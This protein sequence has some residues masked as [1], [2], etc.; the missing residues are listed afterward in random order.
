MCALE[1]QYLLKNQIGQISVSV[2]LDL[3]VM[4]ERRRYERAATSCY[5]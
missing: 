1:K 5:L 3:D 2:T 4:Y